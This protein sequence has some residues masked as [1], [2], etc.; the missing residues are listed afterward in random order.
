MKIGG[1]S[2][3]E[4]D[5]LDCGEQ[6]VTLCNHG[7]LKCICE[8]LDYTLTE[9]DA[10]KGEENFK[11]EFWRKLWHLHLR[12]FAVTRNEENSDLEINPFY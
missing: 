2:S 5:G 12:H 9:I 10:A 7:G 1:P 4:L 3:K 8:F 11:D 6:I